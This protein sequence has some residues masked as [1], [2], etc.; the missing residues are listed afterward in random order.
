MS[1]PLLLLVLL[2]LQTTYGEAKQICKKNSAANVPSGVISVQSNGGW[3]IGGWGWASRDNSANFGDLN[4]GSGNIGRGNVGDLNQG[5][6]NFGTGNQGNGNNGNYNVG[7][8]NCGSFNVG[9]GNQGSWN[10][11]TGNS[12]SYNLGWCNVGVGNSGTG[13][14]GNLNVGALNA[15][16][17]NIGTSNSGTGHVGTLNT[18]SGNVGVSN[19]GSGNFGISNTGNSNVGTDNL[20]NYNIGFYNDGNNNTGVSNYGSGNVGN[21]NGVI[22]FIYYAPTQKS[23]LQESPL[24]GEQNVFADSSSSISISRSSSRSSS[25]RSFSREKSTLT[26]AFK[27]KWSRKLAERV[28]NDL[29]RMVRVF[30]SD[31]E[32]DD[33]RH[34][35]QQLL[36]STSASLAI[37]QYD[38]NAISIVENTSASSSIGWFN[39]NSSNVGVANVGGQSNVGGLNNG[40]FS[41]GALNT[42]NS[43]AGLGNLGDYNVGI[44][45]TG[46]NLTG[47]Q[48]PFNDPTGVTESVLQFASHYDPRAAQLT[49]Y[50]NVESDLN[51]ALAQ[52]TPSITCN[53]LSISNCTVNTP[54][55]LVQS[56]SVSVRCRASVKITDLFC[57]G[58]SFQVFKDGKLWL[59]TPVVEP[60]T[61]GCTIHVDD[62]EQAF[63]DPH[64]SHTVGFLTGGSYKLTILPLVTVYGGGAVAV[65]VDDFCPLAGDGQYIRY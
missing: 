29:L 35:H 16:N 64:F 30:E 47:T 27:K 43:N 4:Y 31:S 62:P 25:R 45:N 57:S 54:V 56:F 11:G 9:N 8:G 26:E 13:N 2:L 19:S 37:T 46:S 3:F 40:N 36:K 24:K 49:G 48:F 52:M 21:L 38:F 44:G 20:G 34:Q 41:L 51:T 22:D 23:F 42:G 17:G 1:T 59:T 10:V 5:N 32:E 65:K 39:T 50:N 33:N 61:T 7:S 18:G 14:A 28:D 12:G 63:Y 15:G 53:P 55:Q 60:G 6:G 58:D